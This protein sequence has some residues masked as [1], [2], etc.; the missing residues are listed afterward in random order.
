MSNGATVGIHDLSFATTEFVLPHTAL[1]EYNGTPVGKYHTG[2]GQRSMS[3]AG[4]RRGHRHPGRGGGR[5]HRRPARHG[6]DPDPGVR[7]RVLDRPGEGGGRVRPL[8]ARPAVGDPGGRAQ[9]GLLRGHRRPAVRAR[10]DPPRPVPEGPGGGE[11]RLQVRAGQPRRGDPGRGRRGDAGHRGPGAGADRGP[12]GPVHRGRDG[13]LAAELPRRGT[14]RRPGVHRRLPPGGAGHLEGLLRA[15]RPS[16]WRTSVPS[17][18]TSRSRRW[19][20]RRTGT[21]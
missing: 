16:R 21:C 6:R 3:V 1:A 7:H 4:R 11:R 13:L 17:A 12:L 2:I 20:T 19:P 18:T 5:A 10:P 15:G 8:A 14:G 9:A